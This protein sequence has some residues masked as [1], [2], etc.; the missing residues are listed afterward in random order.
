MTPQNATA[1]EKAIEALIGAS[2]RAPDKETEVTKEEVSR[3][4]EQ[5]VTLSSE[6]KAALEKSKPGVMQAIKSI[7]LD[8]KQKAHASAARPPMAERA[9]RTAP[10]RQRVASEEFVEAVVIAQVTRLV[11]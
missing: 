6:D 4:V 1:Q 5:R 9:E 8:N 2:L 7:L 10:A 11:A 3:Y